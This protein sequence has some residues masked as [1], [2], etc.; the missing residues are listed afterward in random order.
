L[1]SETEWIRFEP[2][3]SDPHAPSATPIYQTATFRLGAEG[4][5]DFD[6]SRSGNPT[7]SVLEAQ[8]ARVEHG[9]CACAFASGMAAIAAVFSLAETGDVVLAS[10]DLYGGTYRYLTRVVERQG[11]RVAFLDTDSDAGRNRDD[12]VRALDR[13]PRLVFVETPTNPLQRVTDLA[14]L[15]EAV[16]GAGSLLAV[17]NSLSSPYLQNPLDWGADLVVHSGTKFLSGHADVTAGS[18]VTRDEDLG[19]RVA[20]YQNACGAGLAPFDAFLLLRGMKTL[21]L[22]LERQQETAGIIA[23]WLE[24]HPRVRRVYYPGLEGHPGRDVHFRQA[25]G[26]GSVVAFEAGSLDR[27]RAFVARLELFSPTVSFGSVAS[28]VSL[29]ALM[30]HASIP[31]SVRKGR[32]FPEDLVRLSIG[33]E[34]PDDILEDLDRAL[35]DPEN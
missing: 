35:Q 24:D 17:D 18:V 20:F 11:V 5:G 13:G 22:R 3:P 6:Y 33:A 4:A 1:R 2:A 31:E 19:R 34:H 12:L 21:P 32:A 29:P 25:R 28:T 26:A 27:S 14:P 10:M 15:A 23:A 16:H 8:I 7:R 30:S 9:R